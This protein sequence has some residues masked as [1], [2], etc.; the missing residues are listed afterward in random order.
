MA[1]NL[2]NTLPPA[3]V[4]APSLA[5]MALLEKTVVEITADSTR[6]N[7]TSTIESGVLAGEEDARAVNY[8]WG[9]TA[10]IVAYV[11]IWFIYF[12]D[13]AGRGVDEALAPFVTS[14]FKEHAL[15][16]TV[17]VL[18]CVL[19]GVV[20]LTLAKILDIFGRPQGLLLSIVFTTLGLVVMAACNS[21]STFAAAQVLYY[22]GISGLSYC[23]TIFVADTS[24]LR[25][26]GLMFAF[27]H[28]PMIITSWLAGPI[29]EGFLDGPGWR[30][31]FGTLSILT[32][33]FTL[34]L[35]FIF[36]RN[37]RKGKGKGLL[38]KHQT[39]RG[40]LKSVLH[41]ANEF[42]VV[43][44]L[45]LATGLALTLLPLNIESFLTETWA[46]PI[47]ITSLTLGPLL[48][49]SFGVWERWFAPFTLVPYTLLKDRTVL[50]ACMLAAAA[51]ISMSLWEAYFSSFLQVVQGLTVTESSYVGHIFLVTAC[52][53]GVFAGFIIRQT[54]R[55]KWLCVGFGMPMVILGVGLMIHFRQPQVA[56]GHIVLCQ[57]LLGFGGGTNYICKELAVMAATTPKDVAAVIA[58]LAMFSSIG[59]SIGLTVSGVIWQSVFPAGL[60]KYLPVQEQGNLAAIYGDMKVQ[61]SYL[62]G[63]EG[64]S[65]IQHAYGDAQRNMTIAATA[66]IVAAVVF[67]LMWRNIKFEDP[68]DEEPQ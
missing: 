26:R 4:L 27:A 25:N 34:P 19:D 9:K 63:S 33:V 13:A 37:Y 65:A 29:S 8:A 61:L 52:F 39:K 41:Y 1:V 56:I 22:I 30:W 18:A 47:I 36:F 7:S 28:S 60:S 50:G 5:D 54:K 11:M 14:A 35:F 15:T 31:A 48:L 49:I 42:D 66:V 17:E 62:E 21:V 12:V 55:Y 16:P 10:L 46:N 59:E 57:I 38:A 3:T 68:K 6:S 58:T 23:I 43:G 40:I 24:S 20:K 2:E 44:I 53:W 45:L 64:R 67:P 51:H 32:P